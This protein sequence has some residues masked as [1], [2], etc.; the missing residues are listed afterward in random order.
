MEPLEK[1]IMQEAGVEMYDLARRLYPIPRSI[2]GNG[3][4]GTLKVIKE[5]IPNL[6]IHE[7]P[8]GTRVFDWTVPKEWNIKDAY[9]KNSRGRKVIDFQKSNLHVLN[10]SI[11]VRKK[12]SLRELKEHLFTLPEYPEW[13][14]YVSSYYKKNWGFCLS[15][16]D[17]KKLKNDTYEVVIDAVLRDGLLTYGELYLKGEIKE[18]FLLSTYLC[19]P[20]L[21]NDNLSGLALNT[22]LGKILGSKNLRHSYRLL[23][24]PE[25]IGAITWL[26]L[27][28]QSVSKI[29]HGLVVTC[30][31][32]RSDTLV[33]KKTR[34]GNAIIDKAAQ[35]VLIDFGASYKVIDF[36]PPGSDERQYGSLGFRL[37]VGSL[38]R[39]PY[40]MYPEYHT[41]ADDLSLICS[42]SLADSLKKYLEI[43][44][45]VESNRT[46]INLYPKCEPQLGRRG[47]YASLGGPKNVGTDIWALLW[48]LNLCDGEHS[49][50]DIAIR[51]GIKFVEIKRAAD[52]LYNAGLLKIT[53]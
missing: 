43:I 8:T 16:N 36:F 31:G 34:D 1:K 24:I 18:E 11:P 13:I 38:M 17:F 19:H 9:V 40:D 29:K 48:L 23:F 52:I 3:V 25:T 26:C 30:V 39:T 50:L 2:T 46:Y 51:S 12:M 27:N 41:S 49:L 20:A 28:E 45:V 6:I 10:Y 15:Y 42:E 37:P 4:R 32:D 33:Y 53:A 7:V 44:N 35:K 47:V 22:V 14:P 21:A 5:H